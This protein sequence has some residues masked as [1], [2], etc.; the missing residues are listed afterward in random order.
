M[1]EFKIS[2]LLNICW[3]ITVHGREN[4]SEKQ[5]A[6]LSGQGQAPKRL[7]PAGVLPEAPR[8]TPYHASSMKPMTNLRTSMDLSAWKAM[9]SCQGQEEGRSELAQDPFP[10]PYTHTLSLLSITHIQEVV[11]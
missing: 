10:Y 11:Q 9:I 6:R 2:T 1:D 4:G 5:R 7:T 8:T 3:G